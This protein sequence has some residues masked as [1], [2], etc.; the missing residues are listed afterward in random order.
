[1]ILTSF[2]MLMN[3]S[4]A[5]F[6][7]GICIGIV[8]SI[9]S[10]AFELLRHK[11][12]GAYYRTNNDANVGLGQN[13]FDFFFA[14]LSGILY[15]ILTYVFMDGTNSFSPISFLF[16]AF[17]VIRRIIYSIVAKILRRKE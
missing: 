10:L 6:I 1:M 17:F 3:A 2:E 11:R 8:Y 4:C 5:A 13:V 12:R 15:L 7:F 14:F 16:L 9:F